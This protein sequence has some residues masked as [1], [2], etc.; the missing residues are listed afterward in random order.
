[1]QTVTEVLNKSHYANSHLQMR[2]NPISVAEHY[3]LYPF[4]IG[5]MRKTQ[6]TN[7]WTTRSFYYQTPEIRG[8]II[9][10]HIRDYCSILWIPIFVT[11][12]C[13]PILKFSLQLYFETVITGGTVAGTDATTKESTIEKEMIWRMSSLLNIIWLVFL[14]LVFKKTWMHLRLF[15]KC[16][17]HTY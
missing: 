17:T 9:I 8:K 4:D 7:P 1:M 15:C 13:I 10:C 3:G 14:C 16:W 12:E 2:Q 5:R 6:E 11:A